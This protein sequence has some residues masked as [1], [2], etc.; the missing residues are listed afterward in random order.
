MDCFFV[1]KECE[2]PCLRNASGSAE[3][4]ISLIVAAAREI[5]QT[6]G[7]FANVQTSM[8]RK[9]ESCIT[10]R[11]SSNIAHPFICAVLPFSYFC[12]NI[13][14]QRVLNTFS[15]PTFC[16]FLRFMS[17][18]QKEDSFQLYRI[19]KSFPTRHSM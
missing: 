13:Y 8:Q 11:G 3:S 2:I 6:P 5:Q 7:M 9:C 4:L 10:C 17:I 1:D 19:R 14:K 16:P 15:P 12:F 18:I